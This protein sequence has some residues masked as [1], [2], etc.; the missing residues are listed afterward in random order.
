MLHV[1]IVPPRISRCVF[2]KHLRNNPEYLRKL[3]K[4]DDTIWITPYQERDWFR[5]NLIDCI[6]EDE[7]IKDDMYFVELECNGIHY[8]VEKLNEQEI[9]MFTKRN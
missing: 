8:M 3:D 5:A 7:I 2:A 6:L 1:K 4:E 9:S